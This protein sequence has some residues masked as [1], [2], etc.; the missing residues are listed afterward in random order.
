MK[1]TLLIAML[2]AAGLLAHAGPVCAQVA[3]STTT[4]GMAVAAVTEVAMGWSAKKG[5]LGKTVYNDAGEKIGKVDDIII[6]PEKYVSYLI[7]GAGGF[8]GMGKHDVA[9]PIAQI[10]EQG[11][12]ILLPGGTK[13]ALKAMPAFVYATDTTRRDQFV[14]RAEQDIARTKEKI[15]EVEKMAG[16]AA[17]EAKVK[18][19]REMVTVR[20]DMKAAEEK[21]AELKRAGE[22]KWRE[23]ESDVSKAIARVRLSIEKAA[24]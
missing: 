5:I 4:M 12:R 20:Q 9:I 2:G 18:M 10:R 14:A 1:K 17:G 7:I 8:L 15:A 13:A 24:A 22:K 6:T 3:G 19:D 16:A 21:L 11:S 23:F